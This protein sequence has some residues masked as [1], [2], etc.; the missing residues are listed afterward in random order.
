MKKIIIALLGFLISGP[1]IL[2]QGNIE[3]L[4]A[5]IEKNNTALSA[6]QKKAD[7]EKLKNS[8]GIYLQNPE[9]EF[10]YL[11]GDPTEIGPRKDFGISQS[12]DF[13]TVY[14][15]QNQISNIRTEQV[16]M[17]YEK[18]RRAL[19]LKARL[20][21]SDL[22]YTNALKAELGKRLAHAQ[23]IAS[24]FK[25]KFDIGE[26]NILEYNK[27]QLNLLN[28][29]QE[30]ESLEIERQA[31]LSGLASLNGG[32]PIDF[33]VS[34]FEPILIPADFEQWYLGSEQN[35]PVLNWLKQEIELGRKQEKLN[36][37]KGLPTLHAGY[38]SETVV[39]EQFQGIAVGL[40]IPLWENKNNV[41]YAKA[42]SLAM[43]S[44]ASDTK[45]QFYN[46]LK[47]LYTKVVSLQKKVVE[48]RTNLQLYNSSDLLK[49][50]LDVGEISLIDYM[51]ELSIYYDSV[52][53]LLEM[54]RE[55]N[56]TYAELMKHR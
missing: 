6:L 17:E 22:V 2:A 41:K 21:C 12:F 47:T 35:Y 20:L 53:K 31:L 19:L 25:S 4:I 8:T 16:E 11:W 54:E 42:N 7:A 34:E 28:T 3:K 14:K 40:T 38:M 30:L 49:K 10:N 24:A 44:L 32:I 52:T 51:L 29:A 13:P 48:Y 50:A 36:L 55:L 37:A 9:V 33:T 45:L 56:K 27:A 46:R 1:I 23:S 39:G 5:T 18:E 26:S 43:E 15:F